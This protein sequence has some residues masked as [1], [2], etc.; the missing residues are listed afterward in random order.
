M[1]SFRKGVIAIFSCI[2]MTSRGILAVV[3]DKVVIC[4]AE[5]QCK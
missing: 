3:S 1:R 4:L 5:L 2:D